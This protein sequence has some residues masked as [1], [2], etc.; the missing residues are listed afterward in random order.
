VAG[1]F[2]AGQTLARLQIVPETAKVA[3]RKTCRDDDRECLEIW[4]GR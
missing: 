2:F 3:I 1:V 4:S